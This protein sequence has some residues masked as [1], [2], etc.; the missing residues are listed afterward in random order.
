MTP[1][2]EPPLASAAMI[3]IEFTTVPMRRPATQYSSPEPRTRF[4]T[5][6]PIPMHTARYRPTRIRSRSIKPLLRLRPCHDATGR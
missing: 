3:A 4:D 6:I 2:I 1:M 5:P